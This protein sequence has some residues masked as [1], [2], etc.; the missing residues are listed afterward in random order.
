MKLNDI[1][2]KLA[3]EHIAILGLG[4]ENFALLAY[5]QRN[6]F[7]GQ[8]TVF[9]AASAIQ[10]GDRYNKLKRTK[11]ISWKLNNAS[12]STLSEYSFILRSPGAY[13]SPRERKQLTKKGIVIS[14]PMQLFLDL[15]PTKNIIGVTGTKGKGTTSSLIAAILK[16]AKRRVWLGGNI[17]VAPFEFIS[18]IKP[19]DWVVLELSSFQLEDVR[20]SPHIGVL[21]NLSPEH[22]A[23]GDPNNPNHHAS[24]KAYREAKFNLFRFQLKNDTAIANA[25]T[26]KYLPR[27]KAELAYFSASELPSRLPG[28]HNKENI[29]AATLAAKAAGISA[30]DIAKAVAK[31]NGLPYRLEKIAVKNGVAYYNDSFST[32]PASTITALRAF[33]QS[34]ILLAGGADKGSDFTA[35]A[36]EIKKRSK[37]VILFE[38]KALAKLKAA[39][40]KVSYDKKKTYIADSM[41]KALMFARQQAIA[42]DTILLSPGCAS[43]GIFK[44]YKDRGQQFNKLAKQ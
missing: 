6:G 15:C 14:C 32:T 40:Q 7:K 12:Y 42:G 31:F 41:K 38:G 22:L 44:N 35:M 16:Q 10:L 37:A 28:E 36:K 13:L 8:V 34:V 2:K 27:L 26:K 30:K 25:S 24:F 4:A 19:A 23:P 29:A 21:T 11:N 20:S 33:P 17:G 9:D 18:K 1:M 43:F 5:L 3:K 39:L